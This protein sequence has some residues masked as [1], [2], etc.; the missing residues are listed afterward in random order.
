MV[1][2]ITDVLNTWNEL[3]VFSYVIPF[4]LI[5]AVVFAILQK[6]KILGD[7]NRTIDAIVAAAIGLLSLQFDYVSTFF[8]TIFPRFGIGISIFLVA[9]IFIGFFYKP[10]DGVDAWGGK[11]K[12][13]GWIVGIGIIVWALTSWGDWSGGGVGVTDWFGEYFWA[14]IILAAV[15]GVIIWVTKKRGTE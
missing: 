12:W 14:L 10:Q 6:S 3:G 2:T 8:A 5:F 4:L 11:L 7:D 13:I 15:I 9:L 1:L